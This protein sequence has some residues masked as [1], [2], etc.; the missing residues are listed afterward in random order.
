MLENLSLP[1]WFLRRRSTTKA[2]ITC[3]GNSLGHWF[4]RNV[5]VLTGND[6]YRRVLGTQR[7]LLGVAYVLVPH[8]FPSPTGRAHLALPAV[9][10]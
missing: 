1:K 7:W 9:G 10:V 8:Q 4:H 3:G 5:C 2:E 6:E